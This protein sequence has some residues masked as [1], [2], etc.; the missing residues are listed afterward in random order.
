MRTEQLLAA[1]GLDAAAARTYLALLDGPPATVAEIARRT[2]LHRPS[3]YR[4]LPGLQAQGLVSTSPQGKR[5][6]YVAESPEVLRSLLAGLTRRLDVVLPD[7]ERRYRTRGVR[8]VVRVLEG[9][10]G[11]RDVLRDVVQSL[12][13]RGVYYRV[14][15]ARADR[16]A[17]RYLPAEYRRLRD[18]KRLER[19][20][21]TNAARARSYRPRLERAVKV[22]PTRYGLFDDDVSLVIY[23]SKV[24]SIDYGSKVAVLVESPTVA[25]FHRTI[26][27]LLYDLL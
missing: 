1:L 17:E 10:E 9:V 5:L 15:A 25:S 27:R 26:F 6:R 4:V 13:P 8:P 16:D 19:F 22:V 23:G 3:V 21:L 14:S 20:V 7:L 2:G 18:A 12:P 11:I 24:A